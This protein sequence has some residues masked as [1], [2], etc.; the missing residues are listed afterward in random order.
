MVLLWSLPNVVSEGKPQVNYSTSLT[1]KIRPRYS[2]H[3]VDVMSSK[4]RIQ[5]SRELAAMHYQYNSDIVM[6]GYEGLL[7]QLYGNKITN[8]EFDA[9]VSKL[10]SQNTDCP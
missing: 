4:E 8:E 7:D 3:S 1:F 2:D 9:S 6:V 5:F 10:E